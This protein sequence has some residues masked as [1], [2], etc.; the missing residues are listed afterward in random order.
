VTVAL[1][2]ASVALAV[3]L[4]TAAALV[5]IAQQDADTTTAMR[6]HLLAHQATWGAPDPT[7]AEP[8]TGPIQLNPAAGDPTDAAPRDRPTATPAPPRTAHMRSLGRHGTP[9]TPRPTRQEHP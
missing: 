6:R 2:L 8:D 3:S 9:P 1:V 7:P 5:V 4:T